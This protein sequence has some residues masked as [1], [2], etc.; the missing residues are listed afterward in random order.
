MHID[1]QTLS[2][3]Q[4]YFTMIQTIIP[5]PIAWV[6]SENKDG[7]LNLAPFSYFNAVC[8]DPPLLLISTGLKPEGGPKDTRV[9]IEERGDFVV[10]IPH[11]ELLEAMNESSATLPYGTSEVAQ[12]G[13][14]TVPLEGSRLPRLADCRVAYGCELE[15][16]LEVGKAPQALILG[17][18]TAGYLD[19]TVAHKD[20]RGRLTVPADRLD[21]VGRLGA[22]QFAMLGE[23]RRLDRPA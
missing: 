13:L 1:F 2:P 20:A 21:P 4:A 18:I 17:R 9:N 6:L 22:G 23:I 15:R 10:M 7:G 8:A 16:V 14:A 19:D 5:R 12:Q 3:A 11:R